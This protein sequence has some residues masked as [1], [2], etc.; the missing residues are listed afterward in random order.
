MEHLRPLASLFMAGFLACSDS[1][2]GRSEPVATTTAAVSGGDST[3]VNRATTLPDRAVGRLLV[4][5]PAGFSSNGGA[6]SG[7]FIQRNLVLTAAHCFANPNTF[8]NNL[9]PSA[10]TF[11]LPLPSGLSSQF[12]ATSYSA[13][14]AGNGNQLLNF[15]VEDVAQTDMAVVLVTPS[16]T[17]AQ[18]P[19]IPAVYTGADLF[20]QQGNIVPNPLAQVPPARVVGFDNS[21]Q[22]FGGTIFD[23]TFDHGDCGLLG[24]LSF[25][26]CSAGGWIDVDEGGRSATT[27]QGD[28]GGPLS[29]LIGGTV[30]IF[31]TVK[32]FIPVS[33]GLFGTED[34]YSPTYDFGNGNGT[35]LRQFLPDADNDGIPDA[36]DNCPPS[37][38]PYHPLACANH[39]QADD[40]LDGVGDVCDN[41]TGLY[42]DER[43]W[44]RTICANPKQEDFDTD[45]YGD[46]CDSCPKVINGSGRQGTPGPGLRFGLEQEQ[47]SDADG[48]G[49]GDACDNCNQPNGYVNCRSNSDCV[50]TSS[51]ACSEATCLS[52]TGGPL[53]TGMFGACLT[54]PNVGRACASDRECAGGGCFIAAGGRCSKQIDD[55]DGDGLGGVCDTCPNDPDTRIMANSNVEVEKRES[56]QPLGD[57]CDPVLQMVSRATMSP[58]GSAPG[59]QLFTSAAG[60]GTGGSRTTLPG[61]AGYR[62]CSCVQGGQVLSRQ[63]CLQQ[64]QCP[65]DRN[66]ISGGSRGEWV[67]ISL[68]TVPGFDQQAQSSTFSQTLQTNDTYTTEVNCNDNLPHPGNVTE[69]CRTGSLSAQRTIIWASGQDVTAGLVNADQGGKVVGL[70]L[71]HVFPPPPAFIRVFASARDAATAGNLRENYEYVGGPLSSS[72]P[73]LPG[74]FFAFNPNIGC[75]ACAAIWRHDWLTDPLVYNFDPTPL[76]VSPFL[77]RILPGP[78]GIFGIL[79]SPTDPV[80]NV[81]AS[82]SPGVRSLLAQSGLRYLTPSEPGSRGIQSGSPIAFVAMPFQWRQSAIAP[83]AV[84]ESAGRLS[85]ILE[86]PPPPPT[87]FVPGDRDE[88]GAILSATQQSVYLIGGHTLTGQHAG[89]IWRYDIPADKWKHVF[90]TETPGPRVGDVKAVAFD[91]LKQRMLVLDRGRGAQSG[92]GAALRPRAEVAREPQEAEGA[93]RE[94]EREQRGMRLLLLDLNSETIRVLAVF[95]HSDQA[96]TFGLAAADDGTFVL[97]KQRA[98]SDDWTAQG[99]ALGEHEGVV[100]TGRQEG[101]GT[102]VDQ[103]VHSTNGIFL[104]VVAKGVQHFELLSPH[105]GDR[106][107]DDHACGDL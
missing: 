4:P 86:D 60:L 42:C 53:G 58:F 71:S 51:K 65:P 25:S 105:R 24:F 74:N 20:D 37:R 62:Y 31:G 41:C 14:F 18:L 64:M 52:A 47:L 77:G 16:V 97:V 70:F 100:C 11:V 88:S 84:L 66:A 45:G 33:F 99:L 82:L 75:V 103:P 80:Y 17:A 87:R 78:T 22:R 39:D 29:G 32:G 72:I 85:T 101:D 67:P 44:A 19:G 61:Q 93:A 56:A 69:P 83:L 38:C 92:A 95:P 49:V 106:D 30:T 94:D 26:N 34:L 76:R 15:S 54:G 9:P 104:P 35:W 6:C 68:A 90:M 7:T 73:N 36:I 28:S 102:I 96:T 23:I 107:D 63:D 10:I 27:S 1:P 79:G 46:V 21:N 8:I 89:E 40:D 2:T 48:D 5:K 50:C 43:G 81:T 91:D 59:F 98:G 13:R 3:N 12:T 57:K 55:L